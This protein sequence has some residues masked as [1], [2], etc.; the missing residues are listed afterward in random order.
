MSR[1][2]Y[3]PACRRG[4]ALSS[5]P[6]AGGVIDKVRMQVCACR[7]GAPAF[8]RCCSPGGCY[9]LRYHRRAERPRRGA[10]CVSCG[11]FRALP[12]SL[13]LSVLGCIYPGVGGHR[14]A[15]APGGGSSPHPGGGVSR[16]N[17]Q[18]IY[19]HLPLFYHFLN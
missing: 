2:R 16:C 5:K 19:R 9:G 7:G 13:L 8:R 12:T 4:T 10:L 14:T 15:T 6:C 18:L 3:I 1:I 17:S 11:A